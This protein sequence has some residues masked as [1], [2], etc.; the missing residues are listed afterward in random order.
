MT[1]FG[2][3]RRLVDEM[4]DIKMT[5]YQIDLV[6]ENSWRSSRKVGTPRTALALKMENHRPQDGEVAD[7]G[8]TVRLEGDARGCKS[9][10]KVGNVPSEPLPA[11]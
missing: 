11:F 6:A 7:G 1:T 9:R 3:R 5:Q 2:R 8:T 10:P 4:P